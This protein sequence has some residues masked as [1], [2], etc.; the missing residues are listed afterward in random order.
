MRPCLYRGRPFFRRRDAACARQRLYRPVLDCLE[1]RCLPSGGYAQVNL[2]S[3]VPGWA[4]FTPA[5]EW[6]QRYREMASSRSQFE[7]F[8]QT[9]PGQPAN[10]DSP[11]GRERLFSDFI[12][13]SQA[14]ERR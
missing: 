12:K 4:R 13:W 14:R 10:T 9:Q 6:L 8:L 7:Q 3:D 11:E 1:E 2:T 5:E